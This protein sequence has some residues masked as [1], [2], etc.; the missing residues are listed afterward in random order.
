MTIITIQDFADPTSFVCGRGRVWFR[1]HSLDWEQF[2]AHGIDVST[3]RAT[4][5][6]LDMIDKLEKTAQRRIQAG[7]N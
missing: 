1:K 6:N 2:K 7:A 3:L 5:D 4:G